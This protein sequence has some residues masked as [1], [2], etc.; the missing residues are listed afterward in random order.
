MKSLVVYSSKTGN[1][2][3]V[4]QAVFDTLPEPKEIHPMENAP[5]VDGFDFL[6]LGFWVD[7]GTA[8][9]KAQKFFKKIKGKQIGLFGT[10]GAYPDSDHAG[11]SMKKT[12]ALLAGNE[13]LGTFMCQGKVD[14]S[15]IEW[16]AKQFKDDPHHS[17]TPERKA[18]LREAEKH[19]DNADLINAQ[20]AFTQMLE[21][22][23]KL[24]LL[25]CFALTLTLFSTGFSGKTSIANAAGSDSDDEMIIMDNTL[26][27]ATRTENNVKDVPVSTEIITAKEISNM[28]GATA[29]DVLTYAVGVNF[30]ENM[31]RSAPS[32]RGFEGKHTLILI[33]GRRMAGPLGK[34]NELDRITSD[35]IQRIEIIRGPM[36][37]LYGSEAMGGVINIITKTPR[38]PSGSVGF[39][40]SVYNDNS[41]VD[42]T[43]ATFNIAGAGENMGRL[44]FFLSGSV[45]KNTPLKNDENE[46]LSSDKELYS[47]NS[48]LTWK[49]SDVLSSDITFD[50]SNDDVE[51]EYFSTYMRSSSNCYDQMGTSVG[52][53]YD[54]KELQANARA[55]FSTWEKDYESRYAQDYTGRG[56]FH[57][58]GELKDFSNDERETTVVEASASK[59]LMESHRITLGGDWRKELFHSARNSTGDNPFTLTREGITIKGSDYEPSAYSLFL[60][61]EWF[62]GNKLLI[63]PGVRYDKPDD[64]DN[65][66]SPKIGITWF[67]HPQFRV[68]ANYGHSYATPATGQLYKDWYGMGGKYH[69]IGNPDLEPE[70]SN[71]YEIALEGEMGRLGGRMAFFHND[72]D[73]LIDT[74]KI[75]KEAETGATISNYTNIDEAEIKG[76]EVEF[77]VKLH[78]N[79][80]FEAGYAY[81]D[82]IDKKTDERLEQRPKNKVTAKL[83]YTNEDYNFDVNIWGEYVSDFLQDKKDY[84]FTICNLN[85]KKRFLNGVEVYAGV[86]NIFDEMEKDLHDRVLGA[87]Y[88]T[89]I[90]YKF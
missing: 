30:Y 83:F 56:K 4:A 10:L 50:F 77:N 48:K 42:S 13:I 88:Y 49:F 14:P 17:M 71:S 89:G 75:G 82:A 43:E 37:T 26:I 34:F 31:L 61:D 80:T 66:L 6:A 36:S 24:A 1:T 73:D 32:I 35:N 59:V 44:G 53:A 20:N 9:L 60:Q 63:I 58:K 81:L 41:D 5:R 87:K 19:P 68:K 12:K 85:I 57:P 2:K 55:Y 67:V 7:K 64:F 86:D 69:I 72:V 8:D 78:N 22:L 21:K 18:R 54:T 76:S 51:N 39:K 74:V 52:L 79:L 25:L 3:K 29:Q 11:E 15:L 46:Y 38:K 90:N 33:D 23:P 65:E 16:M 62:I 28:A 70:T 84:N 27:T 47:I 40:Y 45:I